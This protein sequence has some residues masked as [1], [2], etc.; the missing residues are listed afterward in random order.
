MKKATLLGGFA[1][2][3]AAAAGGYFLLRPQ[4]TPQEVKNPFDTQ[5]EQLCIQLNDLDAKVRQPE[6]NIDSL[7]LVLE[8]IK[9]TPVKD[10][11]A[12]ETE[13]KNLYLDTKK[14]VAMTFYNT[15]KER[16]EAVTNPILENIEAI[17]E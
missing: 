7:T 9:W 3:A 8:G 1:V 10:G 17:S 16:G 4:P 6:A 15:L 12:Y 11:G 5:Y 14:N 13:K 2:A